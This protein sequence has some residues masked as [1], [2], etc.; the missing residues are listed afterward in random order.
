MATAT[1]T[2]LY[3]IHGLYTY[4]ILHTTWWCVHDDKHDK[5]QTSTVCRTMVGLCYC[6]WYCSQMTELMSQVT[7]SYE[8]VSIIL[9]FWQRQKHKRP[10][11]ASVSWYC[12][13]SNSL[14]SSLPLKYLFCFYYSM[15]DVANL[16]Q[17]KLDDLICSF[18]FFF[19]S[20]TLHVSHILPVQRPP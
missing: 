5:Q 6:L 18:Q 4:T 13:G 17:G 14:S 20:L 3:M 11:E 7:K 10:W 19:A 12:N 8:K 1:Q 15:I 2:S 9:I 16:F